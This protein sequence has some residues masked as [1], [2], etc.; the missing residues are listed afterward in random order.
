M[1]GINETGAGW[2]VYRIGTRPIVGAVFRFAGQLEAGP[3]A[4]FAD[5]GFAGLVHFNFIGLGRLLDLRKCEAVALFDVENR[6]IGENEGGAAVLLWCLL[7][8][9][10]L[11]VA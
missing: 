1:R 10:L 6:V 2:H 9:S 8:V 3:I 11:T 5:N 4:P 7:V